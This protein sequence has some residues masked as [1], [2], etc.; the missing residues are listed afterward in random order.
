MICILKNDNTEVFIK[1]N[2]NKYFVKIISKNSNIDKEFSSR[3]ELIATLE[4][5]FSENAFYKIP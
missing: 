1:K 5:S 4:S 2:N 3:L